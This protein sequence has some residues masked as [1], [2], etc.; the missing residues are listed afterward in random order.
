MPESLINFIIFVLLFLFLSL[1]FFFFHFSFLL[2]HPISYSIHFFAFTNKAPP[3]AFRSAYPAERP[4]SMHPY[5]QG[6]HI[7]LQHSLDEARC[8]DLIHIPIHH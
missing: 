3:F 5:R 4:S 8:I 2:S 7:A 6:R 1:I